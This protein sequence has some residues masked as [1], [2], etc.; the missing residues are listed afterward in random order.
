MTQPVRIEFYGIPRQRAGVASIEVDAATVGAALQEAAELLPHFASDCLD[1][2]GRLR[3][4]YLANRNGQAFTT[5]PEE[6]LQSGDSLLIL[7]AD[8]GG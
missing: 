7:S 2:R 6:P 5:N 3:A 1:G 8:V 4:G